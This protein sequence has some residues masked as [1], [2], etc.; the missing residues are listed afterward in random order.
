MYGNRV[1]PARLAERKNVIADVVGWD[2]GGAGCRT[3][4]RG[5]RPLGRGRHGDQS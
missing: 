5:Q 1:I 2:P 4:F 3:L